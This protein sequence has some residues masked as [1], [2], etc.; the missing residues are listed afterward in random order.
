MDFTSVLGMLESTSVD[1]LQGVSTFETAESSL[2]VEL[3]IGQ[4]GFSLVLHSRDGFSLEVTPG[5]VVASTPDGQ[6]YVASADTTHALTAWKS[7]P[8][9]SMA[10]ISSGLLQLTTASSVVND[11]VAQLAAFPGSLAIG[12]IPDLCWFNAYYPELDLGGVRLTDVLGR[13]CFREITVDFQAS[14]ASLRVELSAECRELELSV[15]SLPT[16]RLTLTSESAAPPSPNRRDVRIDLASHIYLDLIQ[17]VAETTTKRAHVTCPISHG[18]YG[19]SDADPWKLT[20]PHGLRIS[21]EELQTRL[22]FRSSSVERL[23]GE[24][25]LGFDRL[26]LDKSSL[27][28]RPGSEL[29]NMK[30]MVLQPS[31]IELALDSDAREGVDRSSV[32]I[33]AAQCDLAA[34]YSGLGLELAELASAIYLRDLSFS[35]DRMNGNISITTGTCTRAAIAVGNN[36]SDW[37]TLTGATLPVRLA[38]DAN[39]GFEKMGLGQSTLHAH[40]F[41]VWAAEG[42]LELAVEAVNDGDTSQPLKTTL[43]QAEDDTGPAVVLVAQDLRL[44][45]GPNPIRSA[46]GMQLRIGEAATS[47]NVDRLTVDEWYYLKE[48]SFVRL[49]GGGIP[50]AVLEKFKENFLGKRFHSSDGILDELDEYLT[51]DEITSYGSQIVYDAETYGHRK[52]LLRDVVALLRHVSYAGALTDGR[53]YGTFAA[54]S[55]QLGF[56][57]AEGVE[58][59]DVTNFTGIRPQEADERYDVLDVRVN[60]PGGKLEVG[61]AGVVQQ[62]DTADVDLGDA[63]IKIPK[64]AAGDPL[65]LARLTLA[66]SLPSNE[67]RTGQLVVP[68]ATL[69]AGGDQVDL[70]DIQVDLHRNAHAPALPEN[71]RALLFERVVRFAIRMKLKDFPVCHGQEE[72]FSIRDSAIDWLICILN[73]AHIP[74]NKSVFDVVRAALRNPAIDIVGDIERALGDITGFGVEDYGIRI[75]TK[76]AVATINSAL[77]DH[78]RIA[79]QVETG[80]PRV[81]AYV[82]YKWREP[83]LGWPPYSDESGR[84]GFTWDILPQVTFKFVVRFSFKIDPVTHSVDVRDVEFFII[85]ETGDPAVDVAFAGVEQ[86]MFEFL[87]RYPKIKDMVV[88]EIQG[89]LRI[90]LPDNWDLSLA[91]IGFDVASNS[92]TANVEASENGWNALG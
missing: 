27:V 50:A 64:P 41:S 68:K 66:T 76:D 28:L 89:Q 71:A 69:V 82:E 26:E 78:T 92:I 48:E 34:D 45:D 86:S 25:T 59:E 67:Y 40:D 72:D 62:F 6:R 44:V 2:R 80:F 51:P 12:I 33:P 39:I 32:R 4:D 42:T 91:R 20:F 74:Y 24:V 1:H 47:T 7:Q 84:K 18:Q 60:V 58:V 31:R 73:T 16:D 85:P 43:K 63:T 17:E 30:P 54:R 14:A 19:P 61:A 35:S 22:R 81:G 37:L 38:L 23:F 13:V 5:R 15:G 65:N 77:S 57:R 49:E 75:H 29:K 36:A 90:P 70:K 88:K 52:T 46:T 53:L 8:P 9:T 79:V 87:L 83:C 3:H 21:V 55:A 56:D 10:P 11:V